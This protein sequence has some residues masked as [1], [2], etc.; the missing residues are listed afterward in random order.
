MSAG[1][2]SDVVGLVTPKA[3]S[4]WSML[5]VRYRYYD[6][7]ADLKTYFKAKDDE[8]W[9]SFDGGSF[10]LMDV[11]DD[12]REKTHPGLDD[13]WSVIYLTI[14]EH[15]NIEVQFEFGDPGIFDF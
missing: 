10:D 11:F 4:D 14:G 12:Y 3:P 1:E 13:P 2:F 9:R 8:D 15:N 5:Q 7:A 6:D